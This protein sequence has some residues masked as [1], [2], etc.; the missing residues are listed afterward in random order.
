MNDIHTK[1]VPDRM[2][3]SRIGLGRKGK[4]RRIW[5]W[6]GLAVLLLAGASWLYLRGGPAHTYVTKQVSRGTLAVTV[7]ATGT[8]AP[9]SQ[10]DVG[11]EVSGR[12]DKL[13]VDFNDHVKKGQ[14][15]ALINTDQYVAQLQQARATLAQAQAT[16][17][18]TTLTHTRYAALGEHDAISRELLNTSTGDL[19]R[20]AAG[21]KLAQAQVEQDETLLSYCTI[22]SPIDGVVLD[23]KVSAGQTV[24]ST[25][26]T[27]VLYTLASDL[28][29]MELDVDIDE[30]D[31]GLIRSGARATFTVDAYPT[32]L[33]SA[34]LVSIHNAPKTVQG[35]VTYQG[36]LREQNPGGMLRPGMTATAEIEA[37]TIR[38]ALLV[39]NA[40]LRFVPPDDVKKKAPPTPPALNGLNGGRVWTESGKTLKPHDLRL[41]ATDGRSTQV[42][43]GDLKAGDEVVTDLADKPA[44]QPGS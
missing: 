33:F 25:F 15:L 27:P 24:A 23:R 40:A 11:A 14:V 7:S 38:D 5:L 4:R 22:Y 9:R 18:Q 19:A 31:V 43:T 20:A 32:H 42:L 21:V 13:N 8:L 6:V 1:P 39:P 26:S 29:Q 36:V 41:G 3:E 12:I 2:L 30:A 16:L 37:A 44:K 17:Q 35:V 28:S 34:R 10:V